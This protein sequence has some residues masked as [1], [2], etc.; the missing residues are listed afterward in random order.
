MQDL[1]Q[2][3]VTEKTLYS[4]IHI[5][6]EA[7]YVAPQDHRNT[8]D[9]MLTRFVSCIPVV[10]WSN[11]I[12]SQ[13]VYRRWR[14]E[15]FCYNYSLPHFTSMM[16]WSGGLHK[17]LLVTIHPQP[18]SPTFNPDAQLHDNFSPINTFSTLF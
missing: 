1:V 8:K 3:N 13:F 18:Y 16:P 12:K 6:L 5:K 14:K 9:R 15:F 7:L 10:V 4:S 17:M 2:I 11:I